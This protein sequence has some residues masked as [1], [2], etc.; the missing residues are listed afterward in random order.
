MSKMRETTVQSIRALERYR[1]NAMLVRQAF[2]AHWNDHPDPERAD[3]GDP[4]DPEFFAWLSMWYST[5]WVGWEGCQALGLELNLKVDL[6]RKYSK[7]AL[8]IQ[9]YDLPPATGVSPARDDALYRGR[10]LGCLDVRAEVRDGESDSSKGR[11]PG[12]GTERERLLPLTRRSTQLAANGIRGS[13][14]L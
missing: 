7:P 13:H 10:R 14:H 1:L 2:H 4:G 8:Q 5:E 12:D 3:R 9:K 11:R 6:I